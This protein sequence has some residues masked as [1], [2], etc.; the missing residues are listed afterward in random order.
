M[1][2][3]IPVMFS[4]WAKAQDA[5]DF[6]VLND[7]LACLCDH[8]KHHAGLGPDARTDLAIDVLRQAQPPDCKAFKSDPT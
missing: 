8:P 3:T 4:Y 7:H 1:V 5:A 2:S 6:E